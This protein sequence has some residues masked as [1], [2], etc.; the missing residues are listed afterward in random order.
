MNAL[1]TL[2]TDLN[3]VVG[4]SSVTTKEGRM[5]VRFCN[6]TTATVERCSLSS[7]TKRESFNLYLPSKR[8]GFAAEVAPDKS[9]T[10]IIEML[11]KLA[12]K[13]AA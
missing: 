10:E 9:S 3:T 8:A 2:P 7:F 13:A 6:G 11:N 12:A 4:V 5:I 1:I